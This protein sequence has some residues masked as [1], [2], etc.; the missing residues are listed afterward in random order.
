MCMASTHNHCT[1]KSTSTGWVIFVSLPDPVGY[2]A[3]GYQAVGYQA[4]I[5]HE[6]FKQDFGQYLDNLL[7]QMWNLSGILSQESFHANP[8]IGPLNWDK[9]LCV[10]HL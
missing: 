2:Q 1:E 7:N 6:S 4:T 3:V 10:S 5:I 8:L 9:Y